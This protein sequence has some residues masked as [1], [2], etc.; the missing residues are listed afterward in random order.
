MWSKKVTKQK[1]PSTIHKPHYISAITSTHI[2]PKDNQI[3]NQNWFLEQIK[4]FCSPFIRISHQC[5]IKKHQK[6]STN[7][8]FQQAVVSHNNNTNTDTNPQGRTH[9]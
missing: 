6:I 9:T 8:R 5:W 2:S 4:Q 7:G 3:Q 1:Q